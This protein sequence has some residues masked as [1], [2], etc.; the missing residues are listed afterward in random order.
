MTSLDSILSSLRAGET[1][2]GLSAAICVEAGYVPGVPGAK[3]VWN[4]SFDPWLLRF[5]LATEDDWLSDTREVP[6]LLLDAN[7]CMDFE[8]AM[9][10]EPRF[11]LAVKRRQDGGVTARIAEWG[12]R[13]VWLGH[14]TAPIELAARVGAV[15]MARAAAREGSDG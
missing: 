3:S 7:A 12:N 6:D 10:P 2:R 14:F 4:S 8:R 15:L 1:S 13:D 9:A 5:S 11:E